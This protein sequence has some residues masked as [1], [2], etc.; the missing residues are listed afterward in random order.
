MAIICITMPPDNNKY[1]TEYRVYI[2]VRVAKKVL[3]SLIYLLINIDKLIIH[4]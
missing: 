3:A 1:H 4:L 2:C